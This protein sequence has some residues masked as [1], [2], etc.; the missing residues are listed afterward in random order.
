M[1]SKL[2]LCAGYGRLGQPSPSLCAMTTISAFSDVQF[3][4]DAAALATALD[5]PY[6]EESIRAVTEVFSEHFDTGAVLW[7]TTDRPRDRLYYRFFARKDTNTVD[8]ALSA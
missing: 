7:K 6:R 5:A 4:A 8:T 1:F 2:I 3:M